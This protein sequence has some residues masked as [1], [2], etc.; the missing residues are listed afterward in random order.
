V[1]VRGEVLKRG[2][3]LRLDRVGAGIDASGDRK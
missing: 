1:G 2:V 3:P